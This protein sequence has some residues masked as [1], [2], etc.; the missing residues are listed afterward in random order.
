M[1]IDELYD[2]LRAAMARHEDYDDFKVAFAL[3]RNKYA[4][5]DLMGYFVKVLLTDVEANDPE[6]LNDYRMALL[7]AFTTEAE[8]NSFVMVH[9]SDTAMW[10][11]QL[12]KNCKLT[13]ANYTETD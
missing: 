2:D 8:A 9:E 1:S 11:G 12:P 10:A 4:H 6:K 3:I 7:D 13:I 5:S